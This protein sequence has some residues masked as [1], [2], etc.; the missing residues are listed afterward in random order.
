MCGRVGG[1]CHSGGG[2]VWESQE[3]SKAR[4]T[5][6]IGQEGC[7]AVLVDLNYGGPVVRQVTCGDSEFPTGGGM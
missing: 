2:V 1:V 7:P 5:E 6:L 3:D 4:R